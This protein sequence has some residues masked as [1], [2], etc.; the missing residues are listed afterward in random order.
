MSIKSLISGRNGQGLFVHGRAFHGS[1]PPLVASIPKMA[2][3][4]FERQIEALPILASGWDG[5][6]S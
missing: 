3:S 6:N 5:A 1:F 2:T 4:L